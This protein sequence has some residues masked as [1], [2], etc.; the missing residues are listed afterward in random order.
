MML[1]LGVNTWWLLLLLSAVTPLKAEPLVWKASYDMQTLYLVGTVHL[2]DS[3]MYP[4]P[5]VLTQNLRH[6]NGLIIEADLSESVTMPTQAKRNNVEFLLNAKEN[7]QLKR[8]VDTT[9]LDWATIK[10]L[11]PWQVALTLQNY[12][13]Q[14]FGFHS[15]FGVDNAVIKLAKTNGIPVI[16]LET[17]QFQIN[18]LAKQDDNGVAM[19]KQTLAEWKDGENNVHCLIESWKAGDSGNLNMLLDSA[20]TDQS[21]E[22][23][24][25]VN[26]NQNW[27]K[28]LTT[29]PALAKGTFTV[30]VGALHL[31]GKQSLIQLLSQFGYVIEQLTQSKHVSCQ[32]KVP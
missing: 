31:V 5:D 32:I 15:Q 21:F 30:A 10:T 11:A 17:L 6:S 16:G 18:L 24:F 27:V 26:R 1:N 20:S 28:T 7:L 22:Q 2:G 3:S 8:I 14:S 29:D 9:T 19:L 13:F 4:L 25:I 12:Q 23:D